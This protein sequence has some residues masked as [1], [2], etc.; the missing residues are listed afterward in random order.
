VRKTLIRIK[1]INFEHYLE[2]ARQL[3]AGGF[4]QPVLFVSK[5]RKDY[6]EGDSGHIHPL[7]APEISDA[8]VQ[9]RFF[10]NLSAALGFLHI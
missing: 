7:L 5:N 9:I 3:C 2:F 6:W 10:G 4:V 1:S 8:A